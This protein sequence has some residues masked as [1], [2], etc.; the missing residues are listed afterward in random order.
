MN[1]M[2]QL[3]ALLKRRNAQGDQNEVDPATTS[4]FETIGTGDTQQMPAS[5][6][7]QPKPTRRLGA[8][9]VVGAVVGLAAGFTIPAL[10]GG[11]GPSTNDTS[12]TSSPTPGA[13]DE[14][15]SPKD[16][17][18]SKTDKDKKADKKAKGPAELCPAPHAGPG[19]QHK[20][21][22]AP[23]DGT[24]PGP[25]SGSAKDLPPTPPKAK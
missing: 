7:A 5:G 13:S 11:N 21:H 18:D 1:P 6:P 25:K 12:S 24:A 17:P 15:A 16:A 9:L 4:Q 2:N 20:G 3:R 22:P 19:K 8:G 10:A 23:K 14:T